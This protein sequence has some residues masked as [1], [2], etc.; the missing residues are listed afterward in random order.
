MMASSMPR[1]MTLLNNPLTAESLRFASQSLPALLPPIREMAPMQD[2]LQA[3][4]Q[5]HT[6]LSVASLLNNGTCSHL[7]GD[8]QRL[9]G[10]IH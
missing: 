5:P 1:E 7:V 3:A 6:C 8:V 4:R 2:L 9:A 10:S